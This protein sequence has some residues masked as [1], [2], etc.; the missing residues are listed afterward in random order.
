VP[1]V[2]NLPP[3]YFQVFFLILM[4]V[5]S[6]VMTLPVLSSRNIPAP[7]KIG[8]SALL[9]FVLTPT[10]AT[11]MPSVPLAMAPFVLAIAQEV[12]LG[13]AFSFAVQIVFGGIQMAGQLLGIQMGLNIATTLDPVTNA[14]NISYVDQ[15]Y[16]LL[17]GMVF[18]TINGHHFVLQ[19]L[20]LSFSIVPVGQFQLTEAL[21]SNLVGLVLQAMIISIRIGLPIA[22]AL[23]LTDIAF[24][25]IG[26]TAP[27][28][29][30][31]MVGQ[32]VKI[33]VGLI[34]FFLAMPVMVATMAD[35]FGR[36]NG[37]LIRLL[38]AIHG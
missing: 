13:L 8:I 25:I 35:V 12:L 20:Q 38:Q 18:L 5:A 22:G 6:V 32:P 14:G 34:V 7:A 26:R 3:T 9:A 27:Q 29:N 37:D 10:L 15:L 24:L 28:M 36:L 30:I 17:A 2:L 11:Q 23:L 1:D 33:G 16:G 21:S 31:F 19:A 4:R